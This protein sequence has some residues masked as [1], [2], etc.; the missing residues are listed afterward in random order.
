MR[1]LS[2]FMHRPDKRCADMAPIR[3]SAIVPSNYAGELIVDVI[4]PRVE[5]R[6]PQPFFFSPFFMPIGGDL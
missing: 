3:R 2:W 4:G 6:A 5:A 1:D